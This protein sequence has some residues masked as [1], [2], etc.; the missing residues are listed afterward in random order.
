MRALTKSRM[1]SNSSTHTRATEN[2]SAPSEYPLATIELWCE[3][4]NVELVETLTVQTQTLEKEQE[5][6]KALLGA[7]SLSANFRKNVL[8]L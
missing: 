2:T 5:T 1:L 4:A 7:R 6:K 8:G 3:D